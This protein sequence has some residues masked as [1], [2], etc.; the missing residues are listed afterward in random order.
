MAA[1]WKQPQISVGVR[2]LIGNIPPTRT[3][4]EHVS[5]QQMLSYQQPW[6][7]L[8]HAER[9]SSSFCP[10][11]QSSLPASLI[12]INMKPNVRYTSGFRRLQCHFGITVHDE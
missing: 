1:A 2:A 5:G 3:I 8:C 9:R 6:N 11:S 12:C 7:Q 4:R 10:A